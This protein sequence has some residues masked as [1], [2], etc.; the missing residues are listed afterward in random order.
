MKFIIPIPPVTKKNSQQIITNPKTHKLMIIP[1]KKYKEYEKECGEFIPKNWYID[2]PVNIKATFYMPTRRVCD[3]VNLQEAL[4][5]VL[6]KYHVVED[7]N[8]TIIEA[9]DG[10]RVKY[11]KEQPRTEVEIT[12]IDPIYEHRLAKFGTIEHV[13]EN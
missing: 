2:F 6:V 9:M 1:S 3:L 12:A 10:S 11:C 8:Y 5:D 7:D 4:C 13:T